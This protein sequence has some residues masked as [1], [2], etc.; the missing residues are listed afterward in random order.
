MPITRRAFLASAAA[1]GTVRV[2]PSAAPS[3]LSQYEL[4]NDKIAVTLDAG[5]RLVRLT[6]RQTGNDYVG[7]GRHAPWRMYYRSGTSVTGALDL[8]IDPDVQKPQIRKEGNRLAISYA[9]LTADVAREGQTRELQV[10]LTIRLTLKEDSLAWT[11]TVHNRETDDA[12]EITEIWIPWISGVGN[13]GLGQAADVLYWPECAGRRIENPSAKLSSTAGRPS[14]VQRRWQDG[15]SLHLTY[16]WPASMQWFTLNNGSEG[17]YVGSHDETLMTTCLGVTAERDKT[18]SASIVKY[19]FVKA[20]ESWTSEPVVIRLYRGDWH[21]AAR[22]YRT[23]TD[24]WMQKPNPPEWIRRTPGWMLTMMK[25][26]T[27]HIR[28]VYADLPAVWEQARKVGINVVNFF[29]W[30]KQGFDNLYP[31]YAP[32]GAMGGAEGLKA[33]VSKIKSEGGRT[34][35]YTQGQL[36]DPSS[37]FY[38]AKGKSIVAQDIWGYIYLETYGGHGEGTLL[39]VMRNK[40]FGVA[41]PSAAGWYE[42]LASQFEMVRGFGAQGMLFDQMGGRPPYICYSMEHPHSKPSLAAG[43]GKVHNMR[44]LRELMKSRDPDF[45]FIVELAS[46]CYMSWLDIIHAWGIGFWPEPEAFGEMLRYTFP[47]VVITNRDGGPYD[48]RAQLGYAFSIGWRIDARPR[49]AMDPALA[50]YLSRINALRTAHP[51]LLLEGRFV[52]TEDFLCDNNRVASHA[53]VSGNRMAVTLWNPTDVP[54]KVRVI[55]PNYTM[56]STEWEDPRW[57]GIDHAIMPGGIA[58]QIFRRR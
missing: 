45:V 43:P 37:E 41:C 44:R 14:A 24:I 53:F 34:I 32:D 8:E 51:E 36:I 3:H 40:Y 48:R 12:V 47:E 17:L 31:E 7:K 1:A 29:G 52:D 18:L 50:R 38:Q 30:V 55:A 13:L 2:V 54:Q 6:N 22:T 28:G 57:S 10:G 26:Q 9:R 35:L 39:N 27:G 56:E 33:V 42:Q 19:P 49:D 58:V 16:P 15:S 5:G 21:D 11:A 23:W 4:S 46:D 20:G 25:G